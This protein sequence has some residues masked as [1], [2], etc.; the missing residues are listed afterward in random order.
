MG[1]QLDI[2]ETGPRRTRG[3][4]GAVVCALGD[5]ECVQVGAWLQYLGG[6]RA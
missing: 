5:E 3:S 4:K 2:L 1:T 6:Q